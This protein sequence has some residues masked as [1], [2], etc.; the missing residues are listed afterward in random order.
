MFRSET[1]YNMES[2]S[3]SRMQEMEIV[4]IATDADVQRDVE[5]DDFKFFK[6]EIQEYALKF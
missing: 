3:P 1:Y 6:I 5:W 4:E 2:T